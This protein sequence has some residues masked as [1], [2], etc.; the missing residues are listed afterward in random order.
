MKQTLLN[1]L[2]ANLDDLQPES[3]VLES[4]A[5]PII[6]KPGLPAGEAREVV[7]P[8]DWA[9]ESSYGLLSSAG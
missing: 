7:Q 6:I 2:Q 4:S 1:G 8:G 5:K 9:V 3:V